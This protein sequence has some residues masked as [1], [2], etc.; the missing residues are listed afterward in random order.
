[1]GNSKKRTFPAKL[2]LILSNYGKRL[3]EAT[4]NLWSLGG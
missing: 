2:L 1:V 4:R 3:V